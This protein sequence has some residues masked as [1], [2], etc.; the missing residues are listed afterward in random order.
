M[1]AHRHGE[2]HLTLEKNNFETKGSNGALAEKGKHVGKREEQTFL[3]TRCTFSSIICLYRTLRLVQVIVL[4]RER[5]GIQDIL[6]QKSKVDNTLSEYW[7]DIKK[8]LNPA[9]R[10][11]LMR[12]G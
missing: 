6:W 1:Q 12:S 7:R 10:E 9:Y 2:I 5:T 4:S 3:M 8:I 11:M